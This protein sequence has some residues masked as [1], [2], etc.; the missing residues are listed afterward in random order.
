MV[1]KLLCSILTA[2]MILQGCFANKT[3]LKNDREIFRDDGYLGN[4][5]R[6]EL[7]KAGIK[8]YIGKGFH[9]DSVTHKSQDVYW[10]KYG[11]NSSEKK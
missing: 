6:E 4:V 9:T 8:E 7:K 5:I 11:S 10:W 3:H 2:G 1:K